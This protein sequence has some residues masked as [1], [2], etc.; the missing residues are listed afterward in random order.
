MSDCL[1]QIRCTGFYDS[2]K[3]FA[4]TKITPE[5]RVKYY[6]IEMF[7]HDG[8]SSFIN[9]QEHA[10]EKGN[11]LIA[12]PGDMRCSKLHFT[13]KYIHF[14]TDDSLV[15]E[16][17]NSLSDFH[18]FDDTK[19]LETL[20][21]EVYQS[22]LSENR[23]AGVFATAKLLELLYKIQERTLRIQN[24]K[25]SSH[26]SPVMKAVDYINGHYT[27]DIST[28]GIAK[29]CGMSVSY[30]HKKF[31]EANGVTPNE[32][33]NRLRISKAKKMLLSGNEPLS[34]VAEKCGFHSQTYFTYCFKKSV[35]SSP[36]KYRNSG[37][38]TI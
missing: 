12:K 1:A 25:T 16:W 21:D 34:I 36:L 24:G 15:A 26:Q 6:E 22:I 33:I 2:K 18:R 13:A 19:E 32:Y 23:Y 5:R 11:I 37:K 30:F 9:G 4:E 20:F 8:G 35:N 38:Y 3:H 10:I 31:V 27:E 14:E 17:V 29:Q 7:C 28:D